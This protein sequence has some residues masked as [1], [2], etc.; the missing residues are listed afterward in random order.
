M[1]SSKSACRKRRRAAGLRRYK[2]LRREGRL[3]VHTR[4]ERKR[5][6]QER[7]RAREAVR[8]EERRNRRV[9]A[10]AV[11]PAAAAAFI[12][13]PPSGHISPPEFHQ[14]AI[15]PAAAP[16]L[17]DLERPDYPHTDLLEIP[18][19]DP[20][21][22]AL[23]TASPF[24]NYGPYPRGVTHPGDWQRNRWLMHYD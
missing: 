24:A 18:E 7:E 20:F 12:F 23:G 17:A 19:P 13:V 14:L 1:A 6:A 22:P 2:R 8:R 16:W 10:I 11:P 9:A 3:P 21:I 4:A 15:V 5:A